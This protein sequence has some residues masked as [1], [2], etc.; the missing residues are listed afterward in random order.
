M[1]TL[2]VFNDAVR[3]LLPHSVFGISMATL[4]AAI[5]VFE[6]WLAHT[7]AVK[8]NSTLQFLSNG[9]QWVL[10]KIHLLTANGKN[11]PPA[12]PPK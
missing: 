8:A 5:I 3:V 9:L 4:L 11:T 1:D 7:Q 12:A 10:D 2:S 6:Q